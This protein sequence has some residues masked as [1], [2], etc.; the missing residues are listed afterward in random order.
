MEEQQSHE[1]SQPIHQ[2]HPTT[3]KQKKPYR[4]ML[5]IS[6]VILIFSAYVLVNQYTTT[7]EWVKKGLELR[8]GL[9]IAVKT[10]QEI[11]V[12]NLESDLSKYGQITV[13]E[14]SG[15]GGR[16]V[17][18]DGPSDID[19]SKILDELKLKNI[20]TEKASIR[21]VSPTL[22]ESFF[23]QIQ[24]GIIVAFIL[25]GIVVFLLFRNFITPTSVVL[26]AGA[27]LIETLAFMNV[28]GIELSLASFAALLMLI[29][30]SV[31]TD[32]LQSTRVFKG[33]ESMKER[34]RSSVKT[35]MTMTLTTIGVLAVLFISNLNPILT[36]I[37]AVLLIGLVID[38]ASTWLTNSG[39]LM[40]YMNRKGGT[41]E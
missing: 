41:Q 32:I 18:I 34:F 6:L 26:A 36:Q 12:K 31:D 22:G 15:F 38:M 30:Y 14:T 23:S 29:G 25:M 35:G 17:L 11:N 8:G 4:L 16:E 40:W 21:S 39:L 2:Q 19:S 7:G 9:S 3:P 13:K 28:F 27:D 33:T 10:T 1:G 37:S 20:N 5:L 24:I